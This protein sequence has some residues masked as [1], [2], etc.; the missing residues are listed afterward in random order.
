MLLP[1]RSC[2]SCGSSKLPE[3]AA[4]GTFEDK[5]YMNMEA[6][7]VR[8]TP[9]G[10]MQRRQVLRKNMSQVQHLDTACRVETQ[11]DATTAFAGHE[12]S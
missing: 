2:D 9:H 8:E 3:A 12:V 11:F 1:V 4:E 6:E 10:G 7:R 5:L